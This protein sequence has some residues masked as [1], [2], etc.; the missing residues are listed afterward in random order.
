[1]KKSARL[2]MSLLVPALMFAGVAETRYKP[3]DRSASVARPNCII[4]L[5]KGGSLQRTFAGDYQ[6]TGATLG[7]TSRTGL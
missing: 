3:G 6:H 2:F 4:R 5:L 7:A 1:M